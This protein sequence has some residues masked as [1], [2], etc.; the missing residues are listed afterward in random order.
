MQFFQ[1]QAGETIVQ[2]G[3]PGVFFFATQSGELDVFVDGK[4][5]DKMGAQGRFMGS[6]HTG[7][8]RS[9]PTKHQC[10]LVFH[11]AIR[12]K[13]D[14]SFTAFQDRS[15]SE[16]SSSGVRAPWLLFER[17]AFLLTV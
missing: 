2:Q 7:R 14:K 10:D 9:P 6:V 12:A 17:E 3:A 8:L 16:K 13:S 11:I 1:F 15:S 4:A 5:V